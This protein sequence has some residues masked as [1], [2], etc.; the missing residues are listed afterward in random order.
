MGVDSDETRPRFLYMRRSVF[1]RTTVARPARCFLKPPG[2]SGEPLATP[3]SRTMPSFSKVRALLTY[4]PFPS[5][6]TFSQTFVESSRVKVLSVG[7]FRTRSVYGALRNLREYRDPPPVRRHFRQI[8]TTP[9]L[10]R[11]EH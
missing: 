10:P 2:K 1:S 5:V 9:H 7:P 8:G 4:I 6:L 3:G 11:P